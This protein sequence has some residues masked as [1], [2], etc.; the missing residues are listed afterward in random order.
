MYVKLD[1]SFQKSHTLLKCRF[2]VSDQGIRFLL[3]GSMSCDSILELDF[4]LVD[5]TGRLVE[6]IAKLNQ[7]LLET[8]NIFFKLA[9]SDLC[10][11]TRVKASASDPLNESEGLDNVT[12]SDRSRHVS[13]V[14]A[15]RLG[16]FRCDD[17]SKSSHQVFI[18]LHGRAKEGT[19]NLLL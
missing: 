12:K 4:M 17:D 9:V 19:I 14:E 1:V 3:E 8:F 10:V 18:R 13:G 11:V 5:M 6:C 7:A 16:N 2:E 15:T